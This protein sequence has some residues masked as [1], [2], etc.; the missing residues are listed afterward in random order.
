MNMKFYFDTLDLLLKNN[1]WFYHESRVIKEFFKDIYQY[2]WS[3]RKHENIGIIHSYIANISI[4]NDFSFSKKYH[5]H[6][7]IKINLLMVLT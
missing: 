7:D 4:M 2:I 3:F 6:C 5:N 1:I